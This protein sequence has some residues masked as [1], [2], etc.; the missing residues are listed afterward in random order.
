MLWLQ[1]IAYG[2]GVE[3]ILRSRFYVGQIKKEEGGVEEI[4]RGPL[5]L[6]RWYQ[7]LFLT[8]I[9]DSRARARKEYVMK[10]LPKEKSFLELCDSVLN[11]IYAYKQANPDIIPAVNKLRSEFSAKRQSATQE[12]DLKKLDEAYRMKL[13]YRIYHLAGEKAFKTFFS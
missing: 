8:L 6:L 10:N 2:V 1:A 11:H 3:A 12:T 13:G 5:D 7:D 4:I 9:D